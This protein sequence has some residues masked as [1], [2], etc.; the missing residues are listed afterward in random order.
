M[1]RIKDFQQKEDT[2]EYAYKFYINRGYTPEQSSA[3][4]GN[5]L[6]ESTLNTMAVGDSGI[7]MGIAQWNKDRLG[8]LKSKYGDNWTKLDNQLDF[9]DWEL[10]NTHKEAGNAL[11]N[12]KSV[13]QAGQVISDLYE[14]PK[15]KFNYDE[16]RQQHVADTYMKFKGVPLSQEDKILFSTKSV[17]DRDV[18]P[19]IKSEN[20]NL[21]NSNL[22]SNIVPQ[23]EYSVPDTYV[24]PKEENK[25][26]EVKQEVVDPQAEFLKKLQEY[27]TNSTT[28]QQEQ[29]PQE[30]QQQPLQGTDVLGMFNDVS[31]FVD[32]PLMREGG[33]KKFQQG[34]K[35]TAQQEI[36]SIAPQLPIR[37]I[38]YGVETTTP[39]Q[40]LPPSKGLIRVD[41]VNGQSDYLNPSG[42]DTLRSMN[43]YRIYME[44]L[45]KKQNPQNYNLL[46]KA[47]E[48]K[49][50]ED[51]NGYWNPQNWGQPV[52]ISSN[53][54]TMENVKE[55]L[56]A[57]SDTNELRLLQPNKNY[58]F[59]GATSVTEYPLLTEE[60]RTF[61]N[62]MKKYKNT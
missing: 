5:L 14:R 61:L 6:R 17:Y 24:E 8:R 18:A 23:G 12:A 51:N 35:L 1:S 50:T 33:Q 45:S 36:D 15:V 59:K 53:N 41:Y 54:I 31:Q 7:S 37:N 62:G 44:E 38:M 3:I 48:G 43:N 19:Y 30:E 21:H 20:I 55:P 49:I 11:K 34:G 2:K 46:T 39:K 22:I 58:T 57:I 10:K 42:L 56:W 4:V 25:V 16:K 9:V 28:Q 52:K 60:E 32:N 29:T 27:Y 26:E 40:G 13:W 47:Q